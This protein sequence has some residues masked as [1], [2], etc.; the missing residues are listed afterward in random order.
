LIRLGLVIGGTC[1]VLAST[2]MYEFDNATFTF[3]GLAG[4][5]AADVGLGLLHD[6]RRRSAHRTG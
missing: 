6:A 1:W 5:G 2:G 3:F 4:L